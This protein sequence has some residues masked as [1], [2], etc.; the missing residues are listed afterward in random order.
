MHKRTEND[1]AVITAMLKFGGHFAK[2]L[3]EAAMRAD[4]ENLRR[5][6]TTWPEYW[7]K[8]TEMAETNYANQRKDS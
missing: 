2:C 4:S 5:I 6:K 8:Y 3:A 7:V 1:Q